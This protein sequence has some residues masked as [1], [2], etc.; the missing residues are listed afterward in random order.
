MFD[1]NYRNEF[2]EE[3]MMSVYVR[4]CSETNEIL[5]TATRPLTVRELSLKGQIDKLKSSIDEIFK[6]GKDNHEMLVGIE[7]DVAALAA[8][9][10]RYLEGA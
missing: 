5:G 6:T 1:E 8:K 2:P 9:V 10:K 4:K 7:Q 3:G